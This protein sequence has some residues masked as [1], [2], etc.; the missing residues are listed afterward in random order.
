MTACVV[1]WALESSRIQNNQVDLNNSKSLTKYSNTTTSRND[2]K[3]S[4]IRHK[5]RTFKILDLSLIRTWLHANLDLSLLPT[6]AEVLREN[7]PKRASSTK[8]L[9]NCTS[10]ESLLTADYHKKYTLSD[11]SFMEVSGAGTAW[12]D[13]KFFYWIYWVSNAVA[14]AKW[15]HCLPHKTSRRIA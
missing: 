9:A 11:F 12:N 5:N 3:A 2:M 6:F 4:V 7:I 15:L 14:R 1:L 10:D 8:I 13:R